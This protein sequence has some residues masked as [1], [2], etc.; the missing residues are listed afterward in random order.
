MGLG[1]NRSPN[2]PVDSALLQ[3]VTRREPPLSRLALL[4]FVV[5]TAH[6]VAG[7]DLHR[8]CL[9]RLCCVFGL[10][11]P[12]DALFLPEPVRLSFAPIALLGFP[13][14][15][16]PPPKHRSAF[17][18]PRPS[19]RSPHLSV[20]RRMLSVVVPATCPGLLRVSCVCV[21]ATD[22]SAL[23]G[24]SASKVRS[25]GHRRLGRVAGAD[26]LLGFHPS[27]VLSSPDVARPM[28]RL[29]S[30]TSVLGCHQPATCA[31][32]FQRTGKLA[33]LSRD[34]RPSWVFRPRPS[35]ARRHH[36]VSDPEAACPLRA[37]PMPGQGLFGEVVSPE[38][39]ASCWSAQ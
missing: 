29:L 37:P 12:L 28:P 9:S 3:S 7:S 27:R 32:E 6:E 1:L 10:P 5:P 11:R 33:C 15:R 39:A 22:R 4:G 8:A 2:P 14:Q 31:P 17:R 19:R 13:L 36:R 18:H 23:R 21:Q 26:P 24:V 30:C 16:I 34:C 25:S 35:G 20:T 38:H